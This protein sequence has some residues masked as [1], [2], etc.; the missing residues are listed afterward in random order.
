[1]DKDKYLEKAK[2]LGED[3]KDI[4]SALKK[5]ESKLGF[6]NR[7][8]IAKIWDKV[9][10]LWEKATGPEVPVKLKLTIIGALLYLILPADCIPDVIPGIG[11][12]DDVAVIGFVFKQVSEYA[13]PQIINMAGQKV[14]GSIYRKIDERLKKIFFSNL[15]TVLINLLLN[16]I[17][18]MLLQFKVFGEPASTFVAIG[19]ASVIF[20]W[21]AFRVV[22]Y[23]RK[24]GKI[25]L[26][27]TKCVVKARSLSSGVSNFVKN[28]YPSVAKVYAGIEKFSDYIPGLSS[29][30]ELDEI[31]RRLIRHYRFKLF[32]YVIFVLGY[33]ALFFWIRNIAWA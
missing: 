6:M 18:L 20:G 16:V 22:S 1:M 13:L 17:V 15:H 10:L 11:F 25:G 27:V 5:I 30:P 31:V 23:L 2:K 3:V 24:Y 14:K 29:I 12:I 28:E 8:M 9:L 26:R 4:P 19:L 7:G 21:T 33:S 32:L